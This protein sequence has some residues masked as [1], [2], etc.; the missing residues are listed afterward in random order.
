MVEPTVYRAVAMANSSLGRYQLGQ[1][2]RGLDAYHLANCAESWY[3][4]P[5]TPWFMNT[6]MENTIQL[7]LESFED[8]SS[9]PACLKPQLPFIRE[10]A[11]TGYG[12][13]YARD[14]MSGVPIAGIYESSCLLV[15]TGN[16][17]VNHISEMFPREG[18]NYSLW[19]SP[20]GKLFEDNVRKRF[21][22]CNVI[23]VQLAVVKITLS[24]EDQKFTLTLAPEFGQLDP[25]F[26]KPEPVQTLA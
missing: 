18:E 12:Y 6:S 1:V 7:I 9:F 4:R 2:H 5:N 19:R 21:P 22:N 14:E 8:L 11:L 23:D 20:L 26:A 15:G 13:I 25:D 17:M 10:A 3:Q 16:D 24:M